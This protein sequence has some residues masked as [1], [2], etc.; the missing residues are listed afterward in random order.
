MFPRV[1]AYISS[2]HHHPQV[3]CGCFPSLA[4][5]LAFA[6]A[7]ALA[8]AVRA[9]LTFSSGAKTTL[10]GRACLYNQ[11]RLPSFADASVMLFNMV[12]PAIIPSITYLAFI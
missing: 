4:L 3:Y 9:P 7:L 10:A 5:A 6:L 12:S 11:S 1:S 2:Q 8:R